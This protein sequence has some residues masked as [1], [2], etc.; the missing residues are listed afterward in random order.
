MLRAFTSS[1]T[2]ATA[3]VLLLAAG[4]LLWTARGRDDGDGVVWRRGFLAG[5]QVRLLT[6]GRYTVERWSCFPGEDVLESGAWS[7]LGQVVS[8][9]PAAG[10]RAPYLMRQDVVDGDWRMYAPAPRGGEPPQDEVF[11]RLE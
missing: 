10:G 7:K 4:L 9:V 1:A 6:G 11:L 8:F 3:A 5:E 2:W